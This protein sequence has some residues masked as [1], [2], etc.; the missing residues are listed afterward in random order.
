MSYGMPYRGSKSMIAKDIVDFLPAADTFIDLFAGGCAVTHAALLSGKYAHVVSNDIIGTSLLF[1][2]LVNGKKELSYDWVSSDEFHQR[3]H[4]DLV[5]AICWSFGNN[6]RS[7][8]C[9]KEKEEEKR[10]AYEW[11]I[12]EGK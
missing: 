6:P 9:C 12:A 3:K 11:C 7:Y 2:D 4:D 10:K 1:D 8:I 5:T